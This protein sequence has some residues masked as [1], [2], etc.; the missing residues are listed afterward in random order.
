M[1]HALLQDD[2]SDSSHEGGGSASPALRQHQSGSAASMPQG[3]GLVRVPSGT[4]LSLLRQPST[5][6][7]TRSLPNPKEDSVDRIYHMLE[8]NNRVRICS[9][10]FSKSTDFSLF[11]QTADAS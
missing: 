7:P 1:T 2:R 5:G 4:N 9:F 8:M 10:Y 6:Q 3:P 11:L